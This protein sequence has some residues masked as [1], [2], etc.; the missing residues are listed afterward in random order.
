[1]YFVW[2]CAMARTPLVTGF[3]ACAAATTVRGSAQ[4]ASSVAPSM[5][6]ILE[7]PVKGVVT[8]AEFCIGKPLPSR[9]G[10]SRPTAR[11]DRKST[12]LN[13]S[14]GYIS[15]GVFCFKKK[16]PCATCRCDQQTS[17]HRDAAL[18]LRRPAAPV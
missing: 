10:V 16:N 11:Q 5:D 17:S 3:G 7:S 13:S 1:M 2:R 6:L 14:H 12:R 8:A 18:E 9:L 15:Y 4:R